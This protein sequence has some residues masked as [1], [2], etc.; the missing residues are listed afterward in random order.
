MIA[1]LKQ[2]GQL[3]IPARIVKQLGLK[4]GDSFNLLIVDG[5]IYLEPVAMYPKRSLERIKRLIE[6]A[7]LDNGKTYEDADEILKN[8]GI[9]I[10]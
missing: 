1:R 7:R 6:Q 9:E 2:N 10:I 5:G 8:M 3:T 4:T